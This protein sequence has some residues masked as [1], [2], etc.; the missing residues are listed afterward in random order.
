MLFKLIIRPPA[1]SRHLKVVMPTIRLANMIIN[2][3]FASLR[4]FEAVFRL[5]NFSAAGAELGVSQSAISQHV[6]VLEEWL[7]QDLLLR[8]ARRSEPTLEGE[9]LGRAISEGL[10]RVSDVCIDLR[11][12]KRADRTIIISCLP[13]FA[14]TWLFPRLQHFDLAHPDL[15]ISITTDT[16]QF[17]FSGADADVGIRYGL[18]DHPG[19]H[20]ERLMPEH[21]FP[22]CSPSLRDGVPGLRTLSDLAHHTVLQDENLNFGDSSPTWEFWA[23]EAGVTLPEPMRTRRLGQ[24]N[25]VIQAAIEGLGVALGREPL[26]VDALSQGKLVRPFPE[27]VSSPLSYWLVCRSGMLESAKVQVFLAW[28]KAEA[29][30]QPPIPGSAKDK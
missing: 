7:G 11:D 14:F 17:P 30:N 12:R 4:A 2:M 28:I 1:N 18:G 9:R 20:V 19:F 15:S 10:G 13:G 22:V 23:R 24:S 26:V 5:S 29:A 6:K 25:L 27:I 8:G 16:G 21:L 3:P